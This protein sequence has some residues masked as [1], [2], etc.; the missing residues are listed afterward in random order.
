MIQ[1][2]PDAWRG[3]D[4]PAPRVLTASTRWPRT[5]NSAVAVLARAQQDAV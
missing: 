2:A 4:S 3:R 5:P 1:K